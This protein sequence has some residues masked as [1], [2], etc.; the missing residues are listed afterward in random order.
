MYSSKLGKVCM[1]ILILK[2]FNKGGCHRSSTMKQV[3]LPIRDCTGLEYIAPSINNE[4]QNK[5][6]L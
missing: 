4:A 1:I 6:T 5:M 2:I 3:H